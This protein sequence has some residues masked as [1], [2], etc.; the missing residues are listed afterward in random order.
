MVWLSWIQYISPIK[1]STEA[2]V[3]NEF[4][5]DPNGIGNDFE[6]FLNYSLGYN[7][8]IGI[9]IALIFLFRIL[10]FICLRM[11]VRKF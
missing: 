2:M 3:Y 5:I 6:A 4:T 7:N 10:G 9:L 11:R 8:C 1:Y